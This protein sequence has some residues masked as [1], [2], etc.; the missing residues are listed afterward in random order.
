MIPRLDLPQQ[1]D[2]LLL[3]VPSVSTL[4]S[5]LGDFLLDVVEVDGVWLGSP[6]EKGTVHYDFSAG[7]GVGEYLSGA[8]IRIAASP[9]T[10]LARAWHTGIPEFLPDWMENDNSVPSPYWRKR[11]LRF[12]WRSSCAIPISGAAGK[13][14]ILILYSKRPN[15]FGE[16]PIRRFALQLHSLLG[17]ALERLRLLEAIEQS[18]QTFMMYKNALDVSEHGIL[19]AE[20]NGDLP[21]CYVNPAFERI[22]GYSAEE[23][24]GRNCRFL[25][26]AD[27]AQPEMET[28]REAVRQG[29]SCTV[30]LRNYRKNGTMFWNSISIAPVLN[31][32]GKATHFIGIQKDVTDLKTLLSESIHSN[33]IYR[34][35]MGTA[36]L[37]IEGKTEGHLFSELCRLLIESKMFTQVWIGRPNSSGDLEIQSLCS[38]GD[39]EPISDLPNVLTGDEKSMA[40]RAWRRRQLQFSNDCLTNPESAP[41][42]NFCSEN[43]LHAAAAVPLY[44]AGEVWAL[45]T[46]L[47]QELNIFSPELL[48]LIERI[49]RLVGH[50]LDELDLRHVLEEERRYQSWLARHDPVTDLLNRRGLTE[51]VEEAIARARQQNRSMAVA[52]VD[53]NGFRVLNELHGHPTCDLLLRTVAKRL[54]TSL[55]PGDAVGRLGRDQFVLILEDVDEEKLA[56]MLPQI[57]ADVDGPIELP[58]RRT[59]T[60]QTSTG[61]TL[62]PQDNST[63][64]HLL[65]HADRALYAMKERGVATASR[66]MMFQPEA[67]EQE[68][69]RQNAVLA[70]FGKGNVRVHYQPLVNLQTG[71]VMGIEALARLLDSDN[72]LLPPAGFLPHFRP[73]ELTALTFQVLSRAIQD[74]HR[75]DKADFRLRLG[76]NLEPVTLADMKAMQDLRNQIESGGLGP[77][78]IVLELLEHPYTLSMTESREVLLDLKR[79]GARLALDDVGSAYSSLL[80]IKELPA[81]SIKLDRTFLQ[82]LE[83]QPK[84]LRFLMHL[85]DMVQ[86]LGVDLI[87]EGVES[88][89]C[90]DALAALGVR[91]AQGYA[92]AMPMDIE[93]LEHWLRQH[94][95]SPWTGPTTLLGAVALQL[96]DLGMTGRILEQKP[97]LLQHIVTFD[98]DCSCEIGLAIR[99]IGPVGSKLFSAHLAWHGTM[100]SLWTQSGGSVDPLA[101]TAA[102]AAYEEE[103][104]V[105]LMEAKPCECATLYSL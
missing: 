5:R 18:Q 77:N 25:Q 64:E 100:A 20:A 92:I 61:V 70:L 103:M 24:I 68:R 57:L 7:A 76:I 26:G 72:N 38:K 50:G 105:F 82:G 43:K 67:D 30:E 60:I 8:T 45:L 84:E 47:S 37:V 41:I 36:E 49:G 56:V 97:S 10:P 42:Q 53:L 17:F 83:R 75:L 2:R 54:Q 58:S 32:A 21:V 29:K 74:M 89:A 19:I 79:A 40:V 63:P 94:K 98:P 22:T 102:R 46:L 44:R 31:A 96:R 104:F 12:G 39:L 28:I 59:A 16:E 95:A 69:I 93:G 33:A 85:L 48:E 101:F 34:A 3:T 6:D 91:Y 35:L 62:F 27:T 66:W 9:D 13:R 65:R 71:S 14:D 86:T 73:A 1:L 4:Y 51:R 88:Y 80:R 23:A 90:R 78:R 99:A 11:G 52:L 55:K 15:F 87:A 81:D